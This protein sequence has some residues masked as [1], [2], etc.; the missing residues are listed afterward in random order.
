M[1]TH[2]CEGSLLSESY[3]PAPGWDSTALQIAL[4]RPPHSPWVSCK[5]LH[6]SNCSSLQASPPATS[7]QWTT[8]VL[9]CSSQSEGSNNE[10]NK[11]LQVTLFQ[12]WFLFLLLTFFFFL[13]YINM[14]SIAVFGGSHFEGKG[15][16][17]GM[18]S[19]SIFSPL[20]H[21]NWVIS[22]SWLTVCVT[23]GLTEPGG[24]SGQM[25]WGGGSSFI[26]R[27]CKKKKKK[28]TKQAGCILAISCETR[29][30]ARFLWLNAP[31]KE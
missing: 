4:L 5:K 11:L 14:K 24:A 31:F 7:R 12:C 6:E 1:L 20:P 8:E 30:R 29:P 25:K 15:Q 3:E 26:P 9:L 16:Q 21:T 28:A 23:G 22:L 27:Q 17:A 18:Q 19:L 13:G 2:D 10:T